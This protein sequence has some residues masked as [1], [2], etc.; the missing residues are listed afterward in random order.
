MVK[1]GKEVSGIKECSDAL[2]LLFSINLREGVAIR[3]ESGG[4]VL[5]LEIRG[6]MTEIVIYKHLG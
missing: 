1:E 5:C 3:F 6:G 4:Y 2:D